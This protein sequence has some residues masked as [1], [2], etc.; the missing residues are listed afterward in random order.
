MPKISEGLYRRRYKDK[1]TGKW[2][3]VKTYAMTYVCKPGCIDHPEG[4]K[5]HREP[6]G[7]DTL[8]EAKAVRDIRLGKVAE[9]RS[10]N[11][12]EIIMR[13]I[14]QNVLN[15][16]QVH[17]KTSTYREYKDLIDL[18][19]KYFFPFRAI[20]VCRNPGIITK[21]I[22]KMK[23]PGAKNEKQGYSASRINAMLQVLT[24]AFSLAK[25]RLSEQPL[26]EKL[27]TGD[28]SRKGHFKPEERESLYK[29][30][31]E[32]VL[33]MIRVFE[34]TGWRSWSEIASRK[35]AHVDWKAGELILEPGEAKN[36][37]PRIFPLIGELRAI[38]EEQEQVTKE[39]E[40]QLGRIIPWLFHHNGEPFAKF[41]NGRGYWKPTRYFLNSWKAACKAAGLAGRFRHD[42]RRTAIRHFGEVGIGD[43]EGMALSGH[44]SH[45]VYAKY[46]AIGREDIHRAAKKLE[47]KSS[48]T[49]VGKSRN[50]TE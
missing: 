44:K 38:L 13:E 16:T 41:Y 23:Q 36:S 20:D 12:A 40:K 1:R 27:K 24:R 9:G 7:K 32:D 4:K 43:D 22:A 19:L 31:P 28:N 25:N 39:L 47:A 37:E 10:V 35:R 21:F 46:K 48:S 26:I 42:F 15:W 5:Q 33:R 50:T 6:T 34:I 29:H 8:K 18:H 45:T 2:K 49:A 11:S 3:Q 30:L 14:L 17:R